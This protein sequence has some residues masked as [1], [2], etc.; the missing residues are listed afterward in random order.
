MLLGLTTHFIQF[1]DVGYKVRRANERRSPVSN[2][3]E[4]VLQG[5]TGSVA[6]GEILALMGPSGSGKTTLLNLLSGR[7]KIK[8]DSGSITY[9]DQPYS[10][11]LKQ[12][13]QTP[14]INYPISVID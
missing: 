1:S 13:Y 2:S 3:T 5:V 9:N 8:N 7:M 11:A 14:C 6:P 12:R 10:K 4:Y